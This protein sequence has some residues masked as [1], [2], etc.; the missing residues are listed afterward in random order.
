MRNL[1]LILCIV[2][3]AGAV[4][5]GG[6]YFLIG[7]S[8]QE[9]FQ[10]WQNT[11]ASLTAA[12]ARISSLEEREAKLTARNRTLD[13]DLAAAKREL[14]EKQVELSQFSE[15]L[16][17]A[18]EARAAAVTARES[19]M[20]N[21]TTA[22]TELIAL[23]DQMATSISPTE[24]ERY[25]QTIVDLE[26]RIAELEGFIARQNRDPSLIAGRAQ[27]AQILKVGPHNAFV[28]INFGSNHGATPNQRMQL[29]RGTAA[30]GQAEI[31]LTKEHYSIAQVLP[32]TLSGSIRKGDAAF[33]TP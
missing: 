27:H 13:A 32:G 17:L 1:T 30:L 26:A 25:R 14:T 24:A 29:Q 4:A 9:M 16:D 8:K 6:L 22:R 7:N 19:A 3:L 28:I 15:A 21:L 12:H 11:E 33:L 2:A 5:S 20:G 23:R 31:S 10:R 18:E